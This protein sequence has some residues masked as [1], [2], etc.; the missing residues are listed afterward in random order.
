MEEFFDHSFFSKD[1]IDI[2]QHNSN[3]WS[4]FYLLFYLVIVSKILN[5]DQYF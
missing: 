2:F 5:N 4:I 3:E 1:E